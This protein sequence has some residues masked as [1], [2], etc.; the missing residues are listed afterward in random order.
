MTTW[1]KEL[2]EAMGWQRETFADIVS[3]TMT[4]EDM[5]VKFSAGYG[6]AEG[7]PFTVWTS[8]RVYFPVNYDGSEWV[9]SVPRNPNGEETP[10]VGGG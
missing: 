10:H 9:D 5:D 6:C 3:N 4:E 8:N 2:E 7:C 1:R